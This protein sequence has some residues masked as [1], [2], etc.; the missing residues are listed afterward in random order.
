MLYLL[1]LVMTLMGAFG[2]FFLKRASGAMGL[3]ALLKNWNFYLGGGLYG[4]SAVVNI[5]VLRY[6]PYSVVLPMTS[7]TYVWTAV[8]GWRMLGEKLTW[9]CCIGIAVIIC[10]VGILVTAA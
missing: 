2:A 5:Y 7:V 3:T 9:R 1:F 6:L 8:I 4:L 10:G